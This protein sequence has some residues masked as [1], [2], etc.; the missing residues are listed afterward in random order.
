MTNTTIKW[1]PLLYITLFNFIIKYRKTFL[2]PLWILV[3]PTV[4]ISSL[5]F[6]YSR[7][8]NVEAPTLIPHL[9]VGFITWTLINGF[10][11]SST[12]VFQRSRAQIMQGAMN[13]ASIVVTEVFSTTLQFLHQ[14]IIIVVVFV[15][16]GKSFSLYSLISFVGLLL[17]IGNGFWLTYFFGIIGARYRDLTE[18]ISPIM[19]IAFLATPIIWIPDTGGGRSSVM[20]AFLTFNPFYHFLEIVRAPLLGNP[21]A[22]LSWIVVLS[23]TGVG[24]SLA[25]IFQ[26]RFAH[27]IPLWV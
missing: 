7:V 13:L 26:K 17:L 2:G 25:Q 4:F 18:I 1:R 24:F 5:G 21:I 22:P 10:V 12:N 8:G 11:S 27:R 15:V 9:A 3:G 6:L 23:I 16:M 14:V 19:R 20:S